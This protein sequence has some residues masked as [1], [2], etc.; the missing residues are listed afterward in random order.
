MYRG[1]GITTSNVKDHEI[2]RN[3]RENAQATQ[4]TVRLDRLRITLLTTFPS[5]SNGGDGIGDENNI[6]NNKRKLSAFVTTGGSHLTAAFN[7]EITDW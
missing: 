6:M 3:N 5:T 1:A 7:R 4:R 2:L